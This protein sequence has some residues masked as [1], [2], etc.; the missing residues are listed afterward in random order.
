VMRSVK[1]LPLVCPVADR[2]TCNTIGLALASL[3]GMQLFIM[4]MRM[5]RAPSKWRVRPHR[6]CG[7]LATL[8]ESCPAAFNLF[9]PIEANLLPPSTHEGADTISR[10]RRTTA[11]RNFDFEYTRDTEYVRP[12]QVKVHFHGS[13]VTV[14]NKPQWYTQSPEFAKAR[15]PSSHPSPILLLRFLLT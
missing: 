15:F 5:S 4:R 8:F 2:Y 6:C 12:I 1:S 11:G 10:V 7:E 9:G 13:T 14:V 3:I